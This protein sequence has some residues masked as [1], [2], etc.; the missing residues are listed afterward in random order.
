MDETGVPLHP[1]LAGRWSPA[2]F[3][4]EH[5][6]S[7][8]ELASLLE[9]ARWA[10]SAGNSQPWSFLAGGRGE[11]VPVCLVRYLARSSARAPPAPRCSPRAS[12]DRP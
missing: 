3:D 6:V 5:V 1:L 2:R 10:P 12:V 8:A 7:G 4:P 9:A 11:T